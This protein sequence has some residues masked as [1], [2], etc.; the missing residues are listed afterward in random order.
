MKSKKIISLLAA[1][2]MVA[3]C[4]TAMA[5][6]A[7]AADEPTWILSS[8][9][10]TD[11]TNYSTYKS[12]YDW[13]SYGDYKSY[14]VDVKVTGIEYATTVSTGKVKKQN[15]KGITGSTINLQFNAEAGTPKDDYIATAIG[16][17]AKPT[18]GFVGGKVIG[19]V[20][21]DGSGFLYPSKDLGN[22]TV[23]KDTISPVIISFLVTADTTKTTTLTVVDGTVKSSIALD[24]VVDNVLQG[25]E[26][27]N[28]YY[29][30]SASIT[31]GEVAK[32]KYT[33]KFVSE[34]VEVQS[35]EVEE[36]AVIT[37]PTDPV[38][39]GYTFDGWYDGETKFE[40][41][42]T[43]SK[44]VTYTAKFTEISDP[45][46]T[47]TVGTPFKG[48][49]N[50]GYV[51]RVTVE[52][53]KNAGLSYKF[54]DEDTSEVREDDFNLGS[55]ELSNFVFDVIMNTERA[56]VKLEVK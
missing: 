51:W 52:N 14:I 18:P 16:G 2:T 48:T 44:N 37:A 50:K 6:S 8:T 27:A 53:F 46:Q 28:K 55:L 40:A 31:L 4:F 1:V 45:E 22:V 17:L 3:S 56:N 49:E 38:K 9:E 11:W 23:T 41:G 36:G 24:D 13:S 5:T 47:I 19:T 32:T 25:N 34:G 10:I 20:V 15:G 42:T 7:S 12:D 30:A 26:D 54:T 35:D 21:G 43:A 29:P 33:V 39:S